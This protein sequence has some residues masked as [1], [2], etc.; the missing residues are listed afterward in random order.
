MFWQVARSARALQ[1]L[2]GCSG[3]YGVF[4]TYAFALNLGSCEPRLSDL[5]STETRSQI[6]P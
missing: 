2:V 3:M 1:I 5:V 4:A 6:G